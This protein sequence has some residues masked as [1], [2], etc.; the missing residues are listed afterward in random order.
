M[1]FNPVFHSAPMRNHPRSRQM[2]AV[3]IRNTE[4]AFIIELAVPG[5]P[6]DA[7]K[8]EIDN[9]VLLINANMEEESEKGHSTTAFTPASFRRKFQLPEGIN[10][11]KI[12]AR[13][14]NGVLEL[15]I[16]KV[17]PPVPRKIEIG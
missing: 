3:N 5:F 10:S 1:R 14:E 7:I 11:T 4:E 9:Q 16:P 2:P 8:V 15:T 12:K 17:A 13:H 6:K